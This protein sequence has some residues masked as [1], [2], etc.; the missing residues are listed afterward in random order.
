MNVSHRTGTVLGGGDGPLAR[1]HEDILTAVSWLLDL[2]R[3]WQGADLAHVRKGLHRNRDNDA[4]G[5]VHQRVL[6]VDTRE[7][8]SR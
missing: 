1:E 3:E 2:S 4:A 5:D 7:L 6:A 8:R